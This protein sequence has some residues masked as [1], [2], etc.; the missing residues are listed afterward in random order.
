MHQIMRAFGLTS[1]PAFEELSAEAESLTRP[2]E[3]RSP[4]RN[5]IAMASSRGD[6]E[7]VA[8]QKVMQGTGAAPGVPGTTG[9]AG[10]GIAA[11][12]VGATSTATTAG[13]ALPAAAPAAGVSSAARSAHKVD[14]SEYTEGGS[15]Y[16]ARYA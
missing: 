10:S 12:P 11:A 15:A 9:F 6:L 5:I 16:R 14:L 13:A 4:L 8:E 2:R 1:K 3:H 7:R